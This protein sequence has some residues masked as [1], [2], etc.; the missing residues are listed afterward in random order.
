MTEERPGDTHRVK[1]TTQPRQFCQ[2]GSFLFLKPVNL[3]LC[4]LSLGF[5]ILATT[6]KI[7]NIAQVGRQGGE[8]DVDTYTQ[9]IL[10]IKWTANDSIHCST[11][12]ST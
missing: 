12:N 3:E 8:V 2:Q 9:L 4:V 11:G 6:T 7:L 1:Y 5:K 10:C